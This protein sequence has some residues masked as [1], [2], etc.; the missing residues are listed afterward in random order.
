LALGWQGG[1]FPRES[2]LAVRSVA[3]QSDLRSLLGLKR[4]GLVVG[5]AQRTKQLH[6]TQFGGSNTVVESDIPEVVES[7]T[8]GIGDVRD[9]EIWSEFIRLFLDLALGYAVL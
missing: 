1:R 2:L 7:P 6:G 9:E 8:N 5:S 4:L 3:A